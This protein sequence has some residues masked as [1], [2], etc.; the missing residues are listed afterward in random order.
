MATGVVISRAYRATFVDDT[1]EA[2]NKDFSYS[3][4][5][6]YPFPIVGHLMTMLAMMA[7]LHLHHTLRS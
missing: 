2:D 1:F 3:N 7:P 4:H 6:F 5:L